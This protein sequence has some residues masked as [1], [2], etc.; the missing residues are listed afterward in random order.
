MTFSL[1]RSSLLRVGSHFDISISIS[2][3]NGT[4][5]IPCAYAYVY[6]YAYF[7]FLSIYIRVGRWGG[8]G[9]VGIRQDVTHLTPIKVFN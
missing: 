1:P 9:W 6:A 2:T 5:S 4:F 3:R 7:I 8:G